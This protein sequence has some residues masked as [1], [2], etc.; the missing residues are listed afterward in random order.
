MDKL[1]KQQIA[2]LIV[3][4]TQDYTELYQKNIKTRMDKQ[5]WA[6]LHLGFI[7]G[8]KQS[9]YAE[10]EL[11]EALDLAITELSKIDNLNKN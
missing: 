5:L 9:E 1:T 11:I 7:T 4:M 3:R 10:E 6:S 8:M 2:E